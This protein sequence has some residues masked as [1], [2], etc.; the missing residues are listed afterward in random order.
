MEESRQKKL[1]D[2]YVCEM[3]E[4]VKYND[5]KKIIVVRGGGGRRERPQRGTGNLLGDGSIPY[6]N[7]GGGYIR[8]HICQNSLNCT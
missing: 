4:K 2:V 5:L 7:W 6:H 1:D 8:I 3:K